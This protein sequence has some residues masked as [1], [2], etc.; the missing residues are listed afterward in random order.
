MPNV[1]VKGQNVHYREWGNGNI[2]LFLLHGWPADS[3]DYS[4]LGQLLAQSGYRVIVPDFPGWGKT[5]PPVSPWTVSDFRD[6]FHQF[7]EE[8]QVK[9]FVLF[10]H[11]FGGR[12]AIKYAIKYPYEVQALILCA[13]AG[14]RPDPNTLKRRALKLT[15][16]L[17]K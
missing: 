8:L 15:A 10:G 14:I 2:T 12:V 17:G 13:T 7:H 5:P 9:K 4:R 16:A 6:W 1:S 11:S 3:S